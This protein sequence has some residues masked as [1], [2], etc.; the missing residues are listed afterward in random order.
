MSLLPRKSLAVGIRWLLRCDAS[1]VD[2]IAQAY[3]PAWTIEEML[4]ALQRRNCIGM[5]AEAHLERQKANCIVGYMIY[6]LHAKRLRILEFAVDPAKR[7]SGVGSQMIQRLKAKLS[8]FNRNTIDIAVPE[9]A[10][11]MQLFL[12]HHDF[13]ATRIDSHAEEIWMQFDLATKGTTQT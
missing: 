6:E 11:G 1:S 9:S 8:Q 3:N 2:R 4:T 5:V 7:R 13:L 10:L 12:K